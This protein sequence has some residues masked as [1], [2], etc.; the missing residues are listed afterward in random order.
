MNYRHCPDEETANKIY[1]IIC[2]DFTVNDNDI[3]KSYCYKENVKEYS[4]H[5]TI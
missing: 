3:F 2:D 5:W 4:Y 1:K